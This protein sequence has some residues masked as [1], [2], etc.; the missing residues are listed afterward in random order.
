MSKAVVSQPD[1]VQSAHSACLR[2][3]SDRHPGI[4]RRR[5]GKGFSYRDPDGQTIRDPETRRWIASLAIPPAWEQVWIS[6]WRNGHILA[7]GRDDKGRKQYI[8]HPR[9]REVRN[10]TNF[11]GLLAFGEAL[12]AL[13]ER[14]DHDLRR[15]G[16]PR[17]RVLALV[18]HLLECT[19]IRIGNPEYAQSNRSFGLTTLR[20]RHLAV[21][22]QTLHFEFQGKSGKLRELDLR[23][24]RA[25]RLIRK[26]QDL[27]GQE[28]FQYVDE[29]GT[30][31]SIDSGDVN[32]YLSGSTGEHFTAKIFRTW[33]GSVRALEVLAE[34]GPPQDAKQ[35]DQHWREAVRA[36]AERLANTEAVCRQHYVHPALQ[37]AHRSGRLAEHWKRCRRR[38]SRHLE[39][40]EHALLQVLRQPD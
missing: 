26:L 19:L 15:Q 31:H 2:Y 37:E 27:P 14:I 36:A 40:P 6:P 38:T 7:T 12:P 9:W 33:G 24:R 29:A 39:P 28:V 22:G 34:L 17:E 30:R 8:Y 5:C 13:R 23:D 18:V 1:P 25:A 4:T 16:L 20:E 35:A 3:T 32:A 10:E 21:Q 11:A